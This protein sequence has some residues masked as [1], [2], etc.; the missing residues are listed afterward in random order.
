L[1]ISGLAVSRARSA[2]EGGERKSDPGDARIIAD[3][4]RF[5]WRQLPELRPTDD[6]VA[7]LR[8]LVSRRRDLVQDQT[9]RIGRLRAL[10]CGVFPGLEATLWTLPSEARCWHSRGWPRQRLPVGL[11]RDV[12]HDG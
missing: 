9:R 6:R 4:L 1:R 5:R 7:E 10:L 2:Y 8:V 3:Q 12:W 11:V